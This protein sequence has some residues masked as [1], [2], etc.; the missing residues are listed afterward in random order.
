MS[1]YEDNSIEYNKIKIDE[2]PIIRKFRIIEIS[3]T[4]L[5]NLSNFDKEVYKCL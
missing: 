3:D 2:I 5:K 1:K 4:L